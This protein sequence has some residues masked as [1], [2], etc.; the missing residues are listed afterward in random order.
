[1]AQITGWEVSNSPLHFY[2]SP[3]Q[4]KIER[5]MGLS[6]RPSHNSLIVEHL[7][8]NGECYQGVKGVKDQTLALWYA[9]SI[10]QRPLANRKVTAIYDVRQQ[11]RETYAIEK[12][13]PRWYAMVLSKIMNLGWDKDMNGILSKTQEIDENVVPYCLD[14]I[15][16]P[17]RQQN[18]DVEVTAS[19]CPSD[20]VFDEIEG[21][22][23]IV[24]AVSD[25][26]TIALALVYVISP[27]IKNAGEWNEAMKRLEKGADSTLNIIKSKIPEA[28]HLNRA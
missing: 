14:N 2:K 5:E 20:G 7:G 27:S 25:P 19:Y 8:F 15:V 22:K 6:A 12:H 9:V 17:Y 24:K 21:K 18:G 11:N 26:L 28:R 3:E 1:M 10:A 23:L 13:N 16:F 4:Q